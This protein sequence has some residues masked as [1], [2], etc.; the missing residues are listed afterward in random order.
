[1]R[2]AVVC[3]DLGVRM[4]GTKGASLHLE[5]ITRALAEQ[6]H[7]ILLVGVAGHGQPP[8]GDALL[9]AH[10]GRKTGWRRDLQ[11]LR[12]TGRLARAARVQIAEFHPDVVYER[13]SLFGT[14]G[15]RL[16]AHSGAAHVV[17]VNALQR[18]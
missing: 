1:M 2:V 16:A 18:R 9:L 5:A 3:S 15:A 8:P 7:E 13:L 12:F 6:G 14:A 10:P 11:R 17:E 4:P